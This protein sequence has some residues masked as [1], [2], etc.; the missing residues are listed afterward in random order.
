MDRWS[1]SEN[2]RLQVQFPC[3][4][5]LEFYARMDWVLQQE[6]S[7][8]RSKREYTDR[9]PQPTMANSHVDE[10]AIWLHPQHVENRLNSTAYP[11]R[12]RLLNDG[13]LMPF[14]PAMVLLCRYPFHDRSTENPLIRSP[15]ARALLALKK[16]QFSLQPLDLI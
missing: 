11:N 14:L 9:Y 13:V 1:T 15:L 3:R 6:S 10:S 8:L 12:L 4:N 7:S 5:F 2:V 16:A